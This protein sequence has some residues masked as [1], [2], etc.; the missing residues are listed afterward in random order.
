MSFEPTDTVISVGSF[1]SELRNILIYYHKANKF[2]SLERSKKI[3]ENFI[4]KNFSSYV[5]DAKFI[6]S[7]DYQ[8][9]YEY[10]YQESDYYMVFYQ[11]KNDSSKKVN[12]IIDRTSGK[13]TYVSFGQ[14]AK[15][16]YLKNDIIE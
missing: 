5:K 11:D 10:G 16:E 12:L 8:D 4:L 7:S 9:R 15:S 6:G 14:I 13:I 1:L 2:T 3:A